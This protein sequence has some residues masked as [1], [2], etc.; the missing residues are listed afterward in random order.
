[1]TSSHRPGYAPSERRGASRS[2]FISAKRVRDFGRPISPALAGRPGERPGPA[3]LGRSPHNPWRTLKGAKALA[4]SRVW[5]PGRR[6]NQ[7][8][9]GAHPSLNVR[10]QTFHREE[11][12]P[13]SFDRG[14]FP[15]VTEE[16]MH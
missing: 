14:E 4:P 2:N 7:T 10:C 8:C 13:L 1:M 11:V 5:L 12:L 16:E 6:G 15:S 9:R 3:P